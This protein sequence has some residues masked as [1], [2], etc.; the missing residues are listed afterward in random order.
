MSAATIKVLIVDDSAL[1][2]K[3]VSEALSH[4]KGIEVVGTAVDPIIA[5]EKI[6][7]LAPDVLT[8]DIEMPRMDGITFLR[9]IMQERPMP[10]IILS[11]LS[12]AASR[13]AMDA[14]QAGAVDVL[15]KPGSSFSIGDLGE[16]LPQRIRAAA[17]ARLR[18]PRATVAATA[19]GAIPPESAASPAPVVPS[20]RPPHHADRSRPQTI[21][22][23]TSGGP[24]HPKQLIALGASTGGTEAL[25][26]VLTRLPDGLPPIVIVQHIP[27]Y[28]SKAFA[29]R[30][31]QLCAFEVHE[32][33][34]NETL[35]PG[36]AVI[37]P[38]GH[39]LIVQWSGTH[40]ISKLRDGPPVWHQR[41]AV[42]VLFNSIPTTSIPHTVSGILTGMGRDGAEGLLRL[43]QGGA[44]TF[45]QN[46]ESCVVFGMPR[47]AMELGAAD[48][49][50]NLQ[51]C[52]QAIVTGCEVLKRA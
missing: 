11:S 31:N 52:A 14:L 1:V 30:M 36:M 44:R 15:A 43:K 42:D 50:L 28:F 16:I 41:P 18:V 39:H 6:A 2:R 3:A 35:R 37:A 27:A 8:L 12:T 10:V 4:D 25:R 5:R 21:I 32:A 47:A 48:A 7:R 51:E 38:G 46:E 13:Q 19:P 29:D 24:W 45:A 9:Q 40:Y 17:S 20:A 34:D 26:E 33:V 23:P 22:R 49:M